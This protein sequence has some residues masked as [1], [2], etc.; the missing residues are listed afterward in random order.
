MVNNS[1]N[2]NISLL[3]TLVIPFS[4]DLMRVSKHLLYHGASGEEN[5][6]SKPF[7][8]S[9]SCN[10]ASSNAASIFFNSRFAANNWDPLSEYTLLIG[11]PLIDIN[12]LH[13]I[14]KALVLE[15]LDSTIYMALLTRQVITIQYAFPLDRLLVSP[16]VS[17]GPKQ[18]KLTE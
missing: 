17:N 2:I 5:F 7:S 12:R 6:H 14:K 16:L 4:T 8:V 9:N 1:K 18:Y 13:G 11:F 3:I 15:S 10:F